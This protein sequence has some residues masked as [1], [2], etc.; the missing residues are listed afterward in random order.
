MTDASPVI[1]RVR[2]NDELDDAEGDPEA[3]VVER[4]RHHD[5]PSRWAQWR[6]RIAAGFTAESGLTVIVV[7]LTTVYVYLQLGP[8]WTD[9]TPAGGDM[10]AHVWGPA[11]LRDELLPRGQLHRLGPRESRLA[12]GPVV[13]APLVAQQLS[14]G[15][16]VG[17]G[18]AEP[19]Q[20]RVGQL[21]R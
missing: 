9:S 5:D 21:S 3:W 17:A 2:Q 16:V 6:D 14:G 4:K 11:F 20:L 8:I 10:G 12:P 19:E 15:V 1:E 13:D 18:G 7:A